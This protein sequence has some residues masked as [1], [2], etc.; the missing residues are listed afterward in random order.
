MFQNYLNTSFQ[1]AD[2]SAGYQLG[3]YVMQMP[4]VAQATSLYTSLLDGTH[5]LYNG[6]WTDPTSPAIGDASRILNTG[7]D[8]WINFRKGV[9]YAQVR[10]TYAES[11]DTVGQQQAMNFATAVAAKM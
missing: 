7:T 1:P 11:T 2:G 4:S 3:L 5:S 10:L 9:Y 6:T 8:W